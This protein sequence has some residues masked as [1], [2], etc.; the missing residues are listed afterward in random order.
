M[1]GASAR[2]EIADDFDGLHVTAT[3]HATDRVL[4]NADVRDSGRSPSTRL[5]HV[6]V[7]TQALDA[8]HRAAS[9]ETL[10]S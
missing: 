1:S 10:S 7:K 3:D 4:A 9:Q 2:S 6:R 5:S 8:S